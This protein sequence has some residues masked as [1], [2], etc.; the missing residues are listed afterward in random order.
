MT[1]TTPLRRT[2][3]QFMQRFFTDALTFTTTPPLTT[4][5]LR[6]AAPCEPAGAF[7]RSAWAGYLC[8]QTMRPRVRS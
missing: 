1:R 8:S 2:I 4:A 5:P 3:L 6:R 7:D